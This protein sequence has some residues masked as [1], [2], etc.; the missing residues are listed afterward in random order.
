MKF[1]SRYAAILLALLSKSGRQSLASL[2]GNPCGAKVFGVLETE[3]I[4][5]LPN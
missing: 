1:K 3:S 4:K 2:S 5:V